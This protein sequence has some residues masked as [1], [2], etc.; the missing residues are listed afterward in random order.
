MVTMEHEIWK[1]I[2][3][4]EGQYQAST[5]GGIRGLTRLITAV[6]NNK[7]HTKTISGH[8]LKPK[9]TRFGYK[10]VC[11]KGKHLFVHRLV[12]ITFI[13]NKYN[14]PFINHIDSNRTNNNVDNLE[15]V[16]AKENVQ[17]CHKMKRNAD[18]RGENHPL[19]KLTNEDIINIKSLLK[20]GLTQRAVSKKY[21]VAY[22]L[23]HK[24]FHGK[25]W[26]H[27]K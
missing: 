3:G 24:I 10:L 12:A 27:I 14:K 23:I 19:S 20:D 17:H 2:P 21:S 1:D 5:A 26:S 22:T 9:T 15:W 7:E 8:V 25:N 11:L 16:T 18:V 6:R 4:Y 13:K